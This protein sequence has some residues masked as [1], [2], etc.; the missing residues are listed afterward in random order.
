MIAWNHFLEDL[1]RTLYRLVFLQ[2]PT[3]N[4]YLHL[5]FIPFTLI[6][7]I[8]EKLITVPSSCSVKHDLYRDKTKKENAWKKSKIVGP[9]GECMHM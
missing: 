1:Y 7:K 4:F 9:S 5:V 6:A 2:V 3:H 8:E